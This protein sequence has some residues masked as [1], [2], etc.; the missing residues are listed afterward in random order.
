MDTPSLQGFREFA[1]GATAPE[2]KPWRGNPKEVL[3]KWKTLKPT[4]LAMEPVPASHKGLRLS[5]D[6]IRLTG[7]GEFIAA[8]L[9]RLKDVLTAE[10]DPSKKVDVQYRELPIKSNKIGMAKRE[11][12]Y[13]AYV[14][15]VE[16][17]P[18]VKLP[19]L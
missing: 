14:H 3:E 9:A 15:V 2:A 4:P 7:R 11:P 12:R 6:G 17:K 13:V 19:K 5:A 16:K 18:K 10:K 8:V 1:V